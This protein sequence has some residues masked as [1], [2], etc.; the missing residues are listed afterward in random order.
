MCE[1][2]AACRRTRS[3]EPVLARVGPLMVPGVGERIADSND[4]KKEAESKPGPK[5]GD[6]VL[7]AFVGGRLRSAPSLLLLDELGYPPI[8]KRGGDLWFQVFAARYETG[9][10]A[11]STHPPFREG[12]NLFDMENNRGKIGVSTRAIARHFKYENSLKRLLMPNVS[13]FVADYCEADGVSGAG[14]W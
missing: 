9:S 1:P 10:I 4:G 8:D 5:R 7:T 13:C 2:D 3:S 11:L 6:A 14:A 12:G